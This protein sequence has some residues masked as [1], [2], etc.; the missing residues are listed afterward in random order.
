M[1]GPPPPIPTFDTTASSLLQE[2]SRVIESR[3]RLHDSL[4]STLTPA[5]ATFHNLIVPL[6]QEI[7]LAACRLW[8]LTL[9][10]RV[11]TN[12]GI[13]EA[14]REAEA[15]LAVARTTALMRTDVAELVAAVFQRHSARASSVLPG[16]GLDDEDRYLL[17]VIHGEYQRSGAG[18]RDPVIRDKVKVATDRLTELTTEAK[19]TLTGGPGGIWLTRNEL[20]GVPERVLQQMERRARGN[21]ESEEFLVTLR[22]GIIIPVM[23]NAIKEETRKTLFEAKESRFPENVGRLTEILRLRHEIAQCLGFEH[24]AALK[25]EEKM[26]ESVSTVREVLQHARHM[27]QV[28]AKREIDTM[29]QLKVETDPQS[30]ALYSW[31]WSFYTQKLKKKKYSVDANRFSEYFEVQNTL[32]GMFGIFQQIF[33]LEFKLTRANVWNEDVIVYE[34]WDTSNSLTFLGYLYVDLFSREGKFDGASHCAIQ[35]SFTNIS[36]ARTIP[37][38]VLI[39]NFVKH[40]SKPTL[41]QHNEVKT[42]FHELGHGIHHLVSRTKYA[43]SHSRDFVE[44]P[45]IMLENFIWVPEILVRLGK[46]YSCIYSENAR[47]W[48]S[49]P[50]KQHDGQVT[51]E[52]SARLPQDL[53]EAMARTKNVNAAHDMLAQIRLALFDLTI[54]APSEGRT[55]TDDETTLLWHT[56]RREVIGLSGGSNMNAGQAGFQHIYKNYDAGYFSYVTSRLYATD[57]YQTAFATNPMSAEVGKKYR[58]SILEPGSSILEADTLKAFLGRM[59]NPEAYYRALQVGI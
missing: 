39:Y 22:K 33:G 6:Q 43:L 23:R 30:K 18:I 57:L 58:Q 13:R 27:L 51:Q 49:V 55:A 3:K 52:E 8:P 59:P 12:P 11:S 10:G 40:P 1:A 20:E 42:L 19:R 5:T 24:H 14:A 47:T 56:L 4:V 16:D 28:V 9:L 44:I 50:S 38:S 54:H 41:L 53:A 45:S 34:V 37:I 36:G 46:H 2:T 15:Q 29:L 32:K 35:P 17:T 7:N 26:H 48:E 21:D 31:D 25:M